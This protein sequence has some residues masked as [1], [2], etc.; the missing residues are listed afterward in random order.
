M[1]PKKY[2]LFKG[3]TLVNSKDYIFSV[4]FLIVFFLQR[5]NPTC[6]DGIETSFISLNQSSSSNLL[7][8]KNNEQK[9]LK[10][11]FFPSKLCSKSTSRLVN[12]F[13]ILMGKYI[14]K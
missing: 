6:V 10:R 1:D 5:Y 2:V 8:N 11:M 9:L 14:L 7:V 13:C 4:Y 12:I 3:N